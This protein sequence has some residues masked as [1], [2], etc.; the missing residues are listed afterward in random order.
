MEHSVSS[1]AFAKLDSIFDT[2]R[3]KSEIVALQQRVITYENTIQRQAELLHRQQQLS[4]EQA[5]LQRQLN[6]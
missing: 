4:A 5:Q 6:Q 3:S 1:D 2:H